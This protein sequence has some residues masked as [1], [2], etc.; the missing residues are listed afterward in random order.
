MSGRGAPRDGAP[1]GPAPSALNESPG[2]AGAW[3]P[4]QA[5]PRWIRRWDELDLFRA[6][7]RPD[8]PPFTI[9][10]PPPNITGN[11]H[12]GHA[13]DNTLQDILVRWRRMRGDDVLWL[14]G[15]DH[16]GIATQ[17]VVERDLAARGVSRHDLG[18]EKF[19]EEVW[20][21]KERNGPEILGTL[22]ALG[23]SCDW[24]RTRFTLDEGLSR[25]VREVFVRL[26]DDGLIARRRALVNWC[27]SCRTALSDLEVDRREGDAG[28][29][30]EIAY[31]V[32]GTDQRLVVA[33]TRPETML[34]DTAV[35]VHPDDPRHEG[36]A[37]RMVR[38]PLMNRLIPVIEDPV[39]VDMTF[40]TGAV[41]VTPAHDFNDFA[42]G[43]RHG[44]PAITV[45][46]EDGKISAEGGP[47]AGLDRFEARKKI[48]E[49]LRAAGLLVSVKD[50]SVAL[51]VCD[52]CGTVLEPRL[53]TQ[54]FVAIASLAAPALEA[55]EQGTIEIVP[56]L[57]K[58]TYY[59]W[60]RH[61]HDWCIS[62]QLWWGHRIPAWYCAD[63]HITV[64]REA[65]AACGTCG[66]GGLR[67]DEDVLD[68]WFSSGLWPFSTLGWPEETPDLKRYYPTSVL[69]T[70]PDILFFWVARMIMMGLRFQG[71]A[72][73]GHVYL[74]GLVR[75]EHGHKMSKTRGNVIRPEDAMKTYGTDAL[76]F[77]L[78]SGASPGPSVPVTP[79]R[80]EGTRAFATK[81][82]N[83]ARFVRMQLQGAPADAQD[84]PA[85]AA[86]PEQWILSR[87]A[88]TGLEVEAALQGFRF[89]LAASCLYQFL[90]YDFC[91]GYIEM[92]KVSL[93]EGGAR[94]A[95][96]RRTLRTC[97]DTTLRLLHPFM[98]FLTE[99]IA[100]TLPGAR[101]SLA[102]ADWPVPDEA[103]IDGHAES[104]ADDLRALVARVRNLRAEAGLEPARRLPLTLASEDD[105]AL[106]LAV[107]ARSLIMKLAHL[108]SLDVREGR[109][110]GG[111]A[112]RSVSGRYSLEIPTGALADPGGL[113]GRIER[114]LKKVSADLAARSRKLGSESFVSKAPPDVVEKERGIAAELAERRDR[115]TE[116]LTGLQAP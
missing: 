61:I 68:T 23:C 64:A 52:R 7:R 80:L 18:R 62:R 34:G 5:E 44:L 102:G 22:K 53:S 105:A 14:P 39:L 49:D 51:A 74:H 94:A 93:A 98:P 81:V 73:F 92:S 56:P 11:L 77:T 109:G 47:Y 57:W 115:L 15:I 71:R 67:Q 90:W 58:K 91:D 17:M 55:V 33:T 1:P 54:W 100:S 3:S 85:E 28:R 37:G 42:V 86:V 79:A 75:D 10:I 113:R 20:R 48:V 112:L 30:W 97:L 46:T 87:L 111:P 65:P 82:W 2:D 103:A 26:Y 13:L 29:L 9:V 106:A 76:R 59:E 43:E 32:E 116:L 25:A 40:G 72:P 31:P 41:K 16:A 36:L 35:A 99:E 104:Q 8:R 89:D 78:A 12:L 27:P 96:A 60:M 4:G 110:A 101:P 95:A 6:G 19:V 38:L 114:D 84:P 69:V 45:L 63:G 24:S 50:H 88:R 108:K 107:G 70:G 21:W 66:K 83:A